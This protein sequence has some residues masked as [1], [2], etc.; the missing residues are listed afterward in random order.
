[1]GRYI[2]CVNLNENEFKEVRF[3]MN[4][5]NISKPSDFLRYAIEEAVEKAYSKAGI[6]KIGG[7]GIFKKKG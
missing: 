5:L 6:V 3:A 4:V 1:M 7:V 2:L